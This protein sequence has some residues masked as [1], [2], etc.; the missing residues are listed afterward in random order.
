MANP[1]LKNLEENLGL[2]SLKKHTGDLEHAISDNWRP[3]I[4]QL[5]N[6]GFVK[7]GVY[8]EVKDAK[9]MLSPIDKATMI[10]KN[11]KDAV[12][13][14]RNKYFLDMIEIFKNEEDYKEM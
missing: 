6:G 13:I 2:K 14:G 12:H 5:K 3:I 4:E 10:V 9:S 8:D 1:G 7:S 11:I